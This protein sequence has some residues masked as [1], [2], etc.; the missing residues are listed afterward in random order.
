MRMA[1]ER[2][3]LYAATYPFVEYG[4]DLIAMAE[5]EKGIKIEHIT[6]S[7]YDTMPPATEE[8]KK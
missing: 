8:G 5:L 1:F 2:E 7:D 3:A 6:R 4:V